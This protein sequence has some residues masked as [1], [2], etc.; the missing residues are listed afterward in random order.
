MQR[1]LHPE[2]PGPEGRACWAG[3]APDQ[4][5]CGRGHNDSLSLGAPPQGSWRSAAPHPRGL[6]M[7]ASQ[8]AALSRGLQALASCPLPAA[9]C[10][11]VPPALEAAGLPQR[12]WL[13]EDPPGKRH[14]PRLP[15]PWASWVVTSASERSAALQSSRDRARPAGL[16][17]SLGPLH[18]LERFGGGLDRTT[19]DQKLKPGQ[20]REHGG[21]MGCADV[22]AV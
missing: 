10:P 16:G 11:Q 9:E 18:R 3:R 19:W 4:S 22:P 1:G 14:P 17:T 2:R 12:A 13:T 5:G 15:S 7:P 8:G 20:R 6:E 21:G